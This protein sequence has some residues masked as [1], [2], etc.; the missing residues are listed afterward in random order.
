M[1]KSIRNRLLKSFSFMVV[2]P[3]FAIFI[4]VNIIYW[5]STNR[6]ITAQGQM[7]VQEIE[8]NIDDQFTH[9]DAL[10][11]FLE[12]DATIASIAGNKG[13]YSL[14]QL[15]ESN[16]R[17]LLQGYSSSVD[18][19]EHAALI[20]GNGVF[21][22]TDPQ[23]L[24][25][26]NDELSDFYEHCLTNPER[27]F[28]ISYPSGEN[29]LLANIPHFTS[30]LS[31]GRALTDVHGHPFAVANLT[32]RGETL[33]NLLTA[34]YIQQGG[35]SYLATPDG[36]LVNSPLRL[37]DLIGYDSRE[38]L[39]TRQPIQD[40]PLTIINI[41]PIESFFT[42]QTFFLTVVV[43]SALIFVL[44]FLTQI[45]YISSQL[46]QP[47]EELRKRMLEAGQG[48]FEVAYH[49]DSDDEFGDL[50]DSFNKMVAEIKRLIAQV[51]REQASKRK[52][53]IAAL[54]AHIKPH[55]LYNTLDTIHWMARRYGADDIVEAVD[56][57]SDLFRA[58]FTNNHELGT[59]S[60]EFNHIESYLK[61]QKLRY[62]D[63]L[64]YS[65][66]LDPAVKDL[67]VQKTILQPIVENALYHGIK[68][69]GRPGLI[70]IAAQ[71]DGDELVLTVRDNGRGMTTE[72]LDQLRRK[73]I[74]GSGSEEKQGHGLYNV[75][76]WLS[77]SYGEHFGLTIDSVLN[78]GTLVS[79]HHPVL[80]AGQLSTGQKQ[81]KR[82]AS[83]TDQ[84]M[85]GGKET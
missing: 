47:I 18:G 46:V 66:E 9:Y 80:K 1:Q 34:A 84:K 59:V 2:L 78:E 61:I 7:I 11:A 33:G 45:R 16:L 77:L 62:S 41:L 74:S 10:L 13:Q 60:L 72:T 52:A 56:A 20:Y 49:H 75:Q 21:V 68:E 27:T 5:I 50:A 4:L 67:P 55:F 79:I 23:M 48:N 40:L 76:Q 83:L 81:T 58:G 71:L 36:T 35:Q 85:A 8:D 31:I 42:M 44:L 3:V 65:L 43:L 12:R 15:T 29:P 26:S 54:Q 14:S 22:C 57:L 28:Y 70:A 19:I 25:P 51:Y 82:Q 53:E 30:S 69:S 38:Y 39:F 24:H 32:I 73:I 17:T 37:E 64:D 63:I 6:T